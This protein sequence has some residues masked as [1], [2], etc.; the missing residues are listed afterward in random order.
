MQ[1]VHRFS[2]RGFTSGGNDCPCRI[3]RHRRKWLCCAAGEER[4]DNRNNKQYRSHWFP[5]GVQVNDV[6]YLTLAIAWSLFVGSPE[7]CKQ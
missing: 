7:I 3:S 4:Q 6:E 1:T 2:S 5:F